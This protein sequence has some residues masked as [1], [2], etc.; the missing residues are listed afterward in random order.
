MPPLLHL[1][2]GEKH[3]RGNGGNGHLAALRSTHAIEDVRLVA[4]GENASQRREWR[5]YDVHA[6]HQLVGPAIG[7]NLVNHHGKH[8]K[9]LRQLAR[10]DGEAAL[11]VVEVQAVG[12]A[13]LFYF[14][15]EF[16]PHLAVGDGLCGGD[17]QISLAARGHEAGLI[18]AV[19]IRNAEI[20]DGHA[21]HKKIFQH[22]VFDDLHALCRGAFVV[23]VVG[24]G[25]FH[26][27]HFVNGGIVH[28]AEKFR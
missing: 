27:A 21:G 9:R 7:I 2:F 26:A 4:G 18:A 6:A 19:A 10:G 22:S 15:N 13:L 17:D 1:H 14:I 8:L 25:E 28:H 24:A 20:L 16:L 3:G 11:D 23:V 12:L 5:A